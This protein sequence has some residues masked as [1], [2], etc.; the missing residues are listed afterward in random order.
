MIETINLGSL[1]KFNF[2]KDQISGLRLF[3][4]KHKFLKETLD[5]E[6]RGKLM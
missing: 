4:G 5:V 1:I 3:Q 2:I 6:F